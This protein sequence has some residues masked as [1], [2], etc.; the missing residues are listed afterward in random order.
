MAFFTEKNRRGRSRKLC[1]IRRLLPAAPGDI[2][3]R[4]NP[5]APPLGP[6]PCLPGRP[7][8]GA[9]RVLSRCSARQGSLQGLHRLSRRDASVRVSTIPASDSTRAAWAIWASTMVLALRSRRA[10]GIAGIRTSIRTGT[11]SSRPAHRRRLSGG[12]CR[13]R[14]VPSCY[15][16]L[17]AHSAAENQNFITSRTKT[18]MGCI[19]RANLTCVWVYVNLGSFE[20]K[21]LFYYYLGIKGSSQN[22]PKTSQNFPET[23]KT[24]RI[25]DIMI[26]GKF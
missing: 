24:S 11:A 10:R 25:A 23:R 26:F 9:G 18:R 1:C 16:S 5:P 22:F 2:S 8:R 19:A 21:E 3:D 20:K 13:V 4:E 7:E 17:S 6:P 15:S 12:T 14:F